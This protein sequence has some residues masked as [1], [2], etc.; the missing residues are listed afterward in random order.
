MG[1]DRG[2]HGVA[3]A[4]TQ[5][6]GYRNN[7]H[8]GNYRGDSNYGYGGG[9]FGGHGNMHYESSKFESSR[10]DRSDQAGSYQGSK[11][12][13]QSHNT[14]NGGAAQQ[15]IA[16][17]VVAQKGGAA[18]NTD[19]TASPP[20]LAGLEKRIL[21]LN[22]DM[23][24]ALQDAT[25]KENEKFDLISSILI[26]LQTRQSKLEE[27]VKQLKDQLAMNAGACSPQHMMAA[28]IQSSP[29]SSQ[30]GNQMPGGS[31]TSPTAACSPM[32]GQVGMMSPQMGMVS[33]QMGMNQQFG[34]G[35]GMMM[36]DS[37]GN[38]MTPVLM[39]MPQ[40]NSQMQYVTQMMPNGGGM[41]A[42]PQ[43]MVQFVFNG[44]GGEAGSHGDIQWNMQQMMG[45]DGSS[46]NNGSTATGGQGSASGSGSA[47]S[48]AEQQSE[49]AETSSKAVESSGPSMLIHEEE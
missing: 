29:A 44:Q 3:A 13:G 37:S 21:A 6:S 30:A 28:S 41:T 8:R 11:T 47:R 18:A 27:Y 19:E 4:G 49:T 38:C 10:A 36:I 14:A 32:G 42:M 40:G 35:H 43:Q 46:T 34:N 15:S 9:K 25:S 33:G 39:A 24:Q 23:Q 17:A 5:G 20:T 31:M 22:A 12:A 26:E 7:Y 1:M 45:G 48:T 2:N 16:A